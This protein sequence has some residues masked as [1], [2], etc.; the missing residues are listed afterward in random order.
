[1]KGIEH[2]IAFIIVLIV[3][4]IVLWVIYWWITTSKQSGDI[5]ILLSTLKQCCSDRS[6]WNCD[7]VTTITTTCNVPGEKPQTIKELADRVH[8]DPNNLKEFCYCT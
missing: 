7:L 4:L 3:A 2:A 1:M 6:I 5:T 8:I